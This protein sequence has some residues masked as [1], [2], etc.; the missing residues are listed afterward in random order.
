MQGPEE[1]R[2]EKRITGGLR[3]DK[4]AKACVR[5]QLVQT[6]RGVVI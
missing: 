6:D 4:V 3:E 1:L 2:D 5:A